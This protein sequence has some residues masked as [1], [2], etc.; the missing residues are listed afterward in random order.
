MLEQKQFMVKMQHFHL[1]VLTYI[2]TLLL[3]YTHEI[4]QGK[5]KQINKCTVYMDKHNCISQ[6]QDC[7]RNCLLYSK[8]LIEVMQNMTFDSIFSMNII[9]VM[10]KV[11][12]NE[13][14]KLTMNHKPKT[15]MLSLHHHINV[16]QHHDHHHCHW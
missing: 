4:C 9:K 8:F 15:Q 2:D 14:Y 1:S 6:K 10:F 5:D 12:E 13:F 11:N 16:D 7:F 3:K